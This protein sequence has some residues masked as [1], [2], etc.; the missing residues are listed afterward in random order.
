MKLKKLAGSII[1]IMALV[2]M[3][4]CAGQKPAEEKMAAAAGSEPKAGSMEK[5]GDLEVAGISMDIPEGWVQEKPSKSMRLAQMSLPGDDGPAL[6]TVFSFGKG[7]G[8]TIQSNI[9]R[10][11]QQFKKPDDPKSS[12]KANINKTEKDGLTIIII[13]TAGT[14]AASSMGPMGGATE[15]QE[16]QALFGLI[17]EGGEMGNVFI[18]VTG[19]ENTIKA[20]I[21][22]LEAFAAS[23]RK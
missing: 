13:K 20:Q 2:L 9:D 11:I 8:G 19:P 4:A 16:N 10:W 21:P 6:L 3:S 18:K 22:N 23:V 5:A 17:V 1:P 7:K 12:P 15:P 14:F